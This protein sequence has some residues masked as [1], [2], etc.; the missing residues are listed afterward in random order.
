MK[1]FYEEL[2]SLAEV[3]ESVKTGRSEKTACERLRAIFGDDFPV[4][5][6]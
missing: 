5:A 3:L 4:P 6:S 2:Q 1:R